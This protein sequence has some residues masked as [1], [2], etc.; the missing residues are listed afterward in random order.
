MID[1]EFPWNALLNHYFVDESWLRLAIFLEEGKVVESLRLDSEET[2]IP[3]PQYNGK[4]FISGYS[5]IVDILAINRYFYG[6]DLAL[7]CDRNN[8][9]KIRLLTDSL[10][11][12]IDSDVMSTIADDTY[13]KDIIIDGKKL[14]EYIHTEVVH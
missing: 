1:I 3:T 11:D 4:L 12:T 14:Y 8:T 7:I 6:K 2:V 5:K 9:K 13:L 10:Y